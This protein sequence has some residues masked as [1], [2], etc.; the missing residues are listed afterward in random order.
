LA[1]LRWSIFLNFKKNVIAIS[2]Q[3]GSSGNCIYVEVNGLSFL[4][5]AGIC[6]VHAERRLA[7]HGRNIRDVDA[8]I[9]S[10]DHA[11]HVRFAGI[12]QRKYGLPLYM[13]ARTLHT[14]EKRHRLG[15]LDNVHLFL[16]GGTIE[17]G[18]VNIRTIPTPHDGVDGSAF[19]VES[20]QT[21]LGILTD[22]GYAFEELHAIV[23]SLDAVFIESN[24]DPDMLAC[25]PYPESLKRRI[26][27]SGGHLS[28]HE[29]AHLLKSGK[30]LK[31]ACL[32]HLSEHNNN[33]RL[34]L[35]TS[36]DVLNN[37]LTLHFAG[38]YEAT[39]VLEV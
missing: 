39:R 24:Y 22:L 21:R 29:A 5:D 34:A 11:D 35:Q 38:R 17:F 2:L 3:S 4:F 20:D 13:S 25:G 10:H 1:R 9:V 37:C 30:R 36:R 31:W 15:R 33:P 23:P 8:V 26:Q 18:P 6:G 12:Y 28:N 19:V 27:G 32:A 14:S 7:L 16:S